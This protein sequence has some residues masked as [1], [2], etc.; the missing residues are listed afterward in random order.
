MPGFK[1]RL[2]EVPGVEF[3][4]ILGLFGMDARSE[5]P[6]PDVGVA[7]IA[8]VLAYFFAGYFFYAAL[9]AA[10]GAM[11]NSDQEAQQAQMP[12]VLLLIIP[13]LCAQL[14]VSDPRGAPAEVLTLIPFSSPVLMPMRYLL[15]GAS[16]ADVGISLAILLASLAGAVF[17][18]A[19]IYRIGILMYGKRPSLREIAR[20]LRY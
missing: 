19:R 20:W 13:V 3:A 1:Q 18:A 7:E 10:I 17:L 12:V 2:D 5:L 11:V 8:I 15:G 6:I 4:Q 14:V 9:Y 16:Q